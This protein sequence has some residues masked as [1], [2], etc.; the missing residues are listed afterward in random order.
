MSRMTRHLVRAIGP[1]L[2]QVFRRS[3]EMSSPRVAGPLMQARRRG[4]ADSRLRG[5]RRR[6]TCVLDESARR[7]V[8][9]SWRIGLTSC[10][11]AATALACGGRAPAIQTGDIEADRLLFER[12]TVALEEEDWQRAREYFVEIR[13]NYPQSQYRAET[14]LSIGDTYEGEGTLEA[15]VQA[16]EEYQDF[17]SLYP[18]SPRAAYAQYKVGMVHFHQMRRP[19]RDQTETM[20]AIEEFETFITSYPPEHELAEQ[21]RQRLREARDRLSDHDFIVGRFY[22]RFENYPGAIGRFRQILDNDP[23]YTRR[24][25][26]YF[27]LAESL[28]RTNEVTEAIPYFARILDEFDVSQYADDARTR[29]AE[30]EAEQER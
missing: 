29:I 6:V 19:E 17:L 12:G 22:Y 14:R 2:K 10:L 15:Y 4:G 1:R 25:E 11:L 20:N 7:R 21:V 30:L 27:H 3:V 28:A 8:P 18:T 26:V 9:D 13:D 16:L 23:A 24:D 5:V